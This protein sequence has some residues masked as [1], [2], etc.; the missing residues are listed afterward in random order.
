MKDKI[1][2]KWV[3]IILAILILL[4]IVLSIVSMKDRI[5]TEVGKVL[6]YNYDIDR[7]P[8]GNYYGSI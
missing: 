4:A 3:L 1:K 7:H 5:N 6:V 2:E 8:G